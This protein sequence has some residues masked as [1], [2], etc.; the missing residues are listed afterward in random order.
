MNTNNTFSNQVKE[1]IISRPQQKKCMEDRFFFN[2][3]IK[4]TWQL[5]Y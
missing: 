2:W 4:T 5:R 1:N 3:N